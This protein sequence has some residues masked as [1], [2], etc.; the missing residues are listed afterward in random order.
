MHMSIWA[1]MQVYMCVYVAFLRILVIFFIKCIVGRTRHFWEWK[2]LQSEICV[3]L[4]CHA[5]QWKLSYFKHFFLSLCKFTDKLHLVWLACCLVTKTGKK[6]ETVTWTPYFNP[7]TLFLQGKLKC[8]LYTYTC[9]CIWP[10][11]LVCFSSDKSELHFVMLKTNYQARL[12]SSV[13]VQDAI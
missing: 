12:R 7:L 10:E 3:L 13:P 4:K 6:I 8:I 11:L 1:P 9:M 5:N 2:W